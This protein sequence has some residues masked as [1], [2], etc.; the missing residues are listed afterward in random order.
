[1][2]S[3][4]LHRRLILS[5]FSFAAAIAFSVSAQ[6]QQSA[7]GVVYHDVNRNNERDAGE[8][9]IGG[10]GV[11]NGREIV[12]T[13]AEGRYRIGVTDDTIIFVIKP[14][15]WMT[16]LNEDL[17]PRF[18]YIHKPAGSPANFRFPGVAP[19]GPLPASVDFALYP[20]NEP[21]QFKAIFFGDTQPRNIREVEYIA[22]DVVEE[23]IGADAS[24]GVTLGDIAF[25]NLNTFEPLNQAIA[26]I[27]IPWYNVIGNHDINYDAPNDKLS[28]E[29]F[30][31]IYGPSYYSFNHGAAHFVVIDDVEWI[32]PGE[33]EDRGRYRPS[34]GAD[35]LEFLRNDFARLPEDQLVV[36][37]MH[38]P[39]GDNWVEE[40]RKELYRLMASRKLCFSVSAHTHWQAH[41]FITKEQGWPGPE[42]HHHLINVTVCG[43][44]WTGEPDERGIPH[45]TMRGGAPNGYSIV[46]FDGSKYS[47][48]F[49]A[50]SQPDDYQMNI[51][52]PEVIQNNDGKED[53]IFVNVFA[54]SERSVVEMRIDD[55]GEWIP[56]THVIQPDPY[57]AE[58]KKREKERAILQGFREMPSEGESYHLW[59]GFLPD[60]LKPGTHLIRV[61]TTDMF[62]QVYSDQRVIRVATNLQGQ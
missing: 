20:N 34:L 55:K 58:V 19:T 10:V 6:A 37:M 9:G 24:F 5:L 62:G 28:D 30:E 42:P 3:I 18:Y 12:A 32:P 35:Q 47:I 48:R 17:L 23:L 57:Y 22:H 59:Q 60:N 8:Q 15:G 46:T 44:W 49:K 4:Y 29:T 25:D 56:L 39:L 31:R 50:A 2:G 26:L 14:R 43:S 7:A 1:M 45:A 40:D 38:I 33:G 21:E 61:R 53:E 51:Y 52:A 54:G 27:G 36:V 41:R 16:P 11:S 13:D